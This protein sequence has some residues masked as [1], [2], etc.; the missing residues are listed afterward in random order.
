M[1][2]QDSQ[3]LAHDRC[4]HRHQQWQQCLLHALNLRRRVAYLAAARTAACSQA[5]RRHTSQACHRKPHVTIE[6]R[7]EPAHRDTTFDL[8]AQ[9]S[10]YKDPRAPLSHRCQPVCQCVQL[11][12][13]AYTL[14]SC[15]LSGGESARQ[16]ELSKSVCDGGDSLVNVGHGASGSP[17]ILQGARR[18]S[19]PMAQTLQVRSSVQSPPPSRIR[20]P[21]V[22]VAPRGPVSC[23]LAAGSH[24][25]D[26]RVPLLAD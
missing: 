6:F 8:T 5:G 25:L 24:P 1:T 3:Q 14:Q 10:T 12:S 15:R 11:A 21:C 22:R 2:L 16:K 17:D 4:V 7:E 18:G 23:S 20:R 19:R 9:C 13:N 26:P